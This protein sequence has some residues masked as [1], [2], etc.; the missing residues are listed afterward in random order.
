MVKRINEANNKNNEKK[1]RIKDLCA[2]YGYNLT[3]YEE[4]VVQGDF[5]GVELSCNAGSIS[6]QAK[7]D[8]RTPNYMQITPLWG[9]TIN[10]KW[11]VDEFNTA[12]ELQAKIAEI[13][14][15]KSILKN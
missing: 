2:S 14:G 7:T 9:R 1:N 5:W 13:I 12:L 3:K 15:A 6:I 8:Y 11:Q 4:V 10:A